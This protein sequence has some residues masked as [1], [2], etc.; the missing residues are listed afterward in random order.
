M[1]NCGKC[2]QLIGIAKNQIIGA[3]IPN[4]NII[5]KAP[6][7]PWHGKTVVVSIYIC[8]NCIDQIH[9]HLSGYAGK[10]GAIITRH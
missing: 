9:D 3:H 5:L 4:F 7:K 1:A 2:G 10:P 6:G 8:M